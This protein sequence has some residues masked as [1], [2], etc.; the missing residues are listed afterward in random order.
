[1]IK[2]LRVDDR[3]IHGQVAVVWSK[4]LGVN[5]I[6]VANDE[7]IKN[8]MQMMAIKMAVPANIKAVIKG[9]DDA[10]NMLNDPRAKELKIFVVVSNPRDAHRI[11]QKVANIPLINIGNS[12]RMGTSTGDMA[13]KT[14]LDKNIFADEEDIKYF[15]LL[16]ESQTKTNV[17]VV[18]SDI[19]K[20][21]K[22]IL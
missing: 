14:Q 13:K 17:Q 18:P 2:M 6:V 1:M 9:V 8:D 11:N 5:R 15:K 4:Y 21:L 7:I 3:L 20:E 19:D 22:S 10:I 16:S 12:G